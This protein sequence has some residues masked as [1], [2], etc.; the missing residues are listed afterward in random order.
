MVTGEEHQAA[1]PP[2]LHRPTKIDAHAF[3]KGYFE[4]CQKVTEVLYYIL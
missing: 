3:E 1:P 4:I 2:L